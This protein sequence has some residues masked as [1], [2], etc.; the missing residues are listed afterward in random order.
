M[1]VA[2][3]TGLTYM[4]VKP[5]KKGGAT[6]S[7]L[8]RGGWKQSFHIA[9]VLAQWAPCLQCNGIQVLVA[10]YVAVLY[11]DEPEEPGATKLPTCDVDEARNLRV[12]VYRLPE[13]WKHMQGR[14]MVGRAG[15]R[16]VRLPDPRPRSSLSTYLW[17]DHMLLYIYRYIYIYIYIL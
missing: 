9:K 2:S 16:Q 8:K 14:M 4:G 5:N 6:I 15:L 10:V 17:L 11:G 1:Y 13:P 12:L 3:C 7:V